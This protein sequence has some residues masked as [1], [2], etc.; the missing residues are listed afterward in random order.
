ML[1]NP[2]SQVISLNLW[3]CWAV[4]GLLALAGVLAIVGSVMMGKGNRILLVG[5]VIDLLS[6]AVFAI[7][8][9]NELSTVASGLD[10]F[11]TASG[12]WGTLAT[13][14]SFGFWGALVAGVAMLVAAT[15]GGA[16][17]IAPPFAVLPH[18]P[19][20]APIGARLGESG[21]ELGPNGQASPAAL[22]RRPRGVKLLIAYCI[23]LGICAVASI[24]FVSSL[25]DGLRQ[26]SPSVGGMGIPDTVYFWGLLA[27]SAVMDIVVAFGLLKRMKLVRTLA[28]MLSIAAVVCAV[29]VTCFIAV[30]LTSP[31]L[32]GIAAETPLSGDIAIVL[33]GAI[34]AAAFVGIA[35]PLAAFR[36]L[37][38]PIAMEYF[39]IVE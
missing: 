12:S 33:Y 32:L 27:F 38:R 31:S 14:L 8:L 10:L 9:Q 26:L 21:Q 18:G 16:A 39:G 13:Y 2:P 35:L 24:P 25:V 17:V 3:F 37:S 30:L 28:R 15:R 36:Y 23:I 34:I 22:M 29:I 1:A 20:V 5:G 11:K 19:E 6:V 7:G 4:L